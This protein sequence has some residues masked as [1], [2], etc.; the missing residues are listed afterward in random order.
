MCDTSPGAAGCVRD[1]LLLCV[2]LPRQQPGVWVQPSSSSFSVKINTIKN[3][4]IMIDRFA[5]LIIVNIL[6]GCIAPTAVFMLR[7]LT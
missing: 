4:T 7:Y 1:P 3:V 2:Q 6:A 5:F